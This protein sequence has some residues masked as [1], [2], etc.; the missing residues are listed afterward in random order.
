VR[1]RGGKIIHYHGTEDNLI[2]PFGSWHYV[3]SVFDRYGVEETRSFMRSFFYPGVGHCSGGAPGAPQP[4]VTKLLKAL[5][6]WVET[7]VAPEHVVARTADNS[8]SR[9]V[10]AYPDE[11]IYRGTG[12]SDDHRFFGCRRRL[13]EPP[14]LHA[15]SA[16]AERYHEAREPLAASSVTAT[17]SARVSEN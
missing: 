7:G 11:T 17:T 9:K 3:S 10:C 2:I 6:Q 16:T 5:E 12:S 15:E 13:V 14:D 1:A 8:R 4:D